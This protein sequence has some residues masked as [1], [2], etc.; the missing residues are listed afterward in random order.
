M[1]VIPGTERTEPFAVEAEGGG[2][3]WGEAIAQSWRNRFDHKQE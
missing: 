3:G 1:I 2:E